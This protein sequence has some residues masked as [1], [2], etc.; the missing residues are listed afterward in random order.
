M[1]VTGSTKNVTATNLRVESIGS[2]GVETRHLTIDVDNLTV[3]SASGSIYVT[4]D[5]TVAVRDVS[6]TV[7]QLFNA[8]IITV[9]MLRKVIWSQNKTATSL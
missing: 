4:E 1:N 9:T 8:S 2:I 6:L 3:F 5:D 7:T